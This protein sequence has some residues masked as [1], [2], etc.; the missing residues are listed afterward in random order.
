M[1]ASERR[2]RLLAASALVVCPLVF[3][4][5]VFE[6]AFRI[7]GALG[8]VPLSAELERDGERGWR[9][10]PNFHF[11]GMK[12]DAAD[13]EHPVEIVTDANGF[14]AFGDPG[15]AKCR[16]FFIG[17][18]F[19]FAKDVS[20]SEPFHAVA[21]RRLDLEV[22]AYGADGYG[23]L[24]ELL[25]LDAWMDRIRPDAVVWQFCRNDFIGNQPEFTRGSA[26]N[27]CHVAQ[28]FLF[29]DGSIR[30]I[31]PG[32]GRWSQGVRP[33]PSA[34]LRSLAYRLDNRN[35]FPTLENTVENIIEREGP[36]FPPFQRAAE[37]TERLFGKIQAR[38]G[39]TPL[40]VFDVEAREP[41][42]GAF[43]DICVRRGLARVE[44][45]AEAIQ[46]AAAGGTVVF[47]E[48]GGH[49]NAEGHRICG[50]LLAEALRPL[51]QARRS[52]PVPEDRR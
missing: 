41:Y 12:R 18:S 43:R 15:S 34:L 47:A 8:P 21:G 9:T 32:E 46:Q 40:L 5:L 20:Q 29:P 49:W 26:K 10:R 11:S 25:V 44:G 14:R 38:C 35:G 24:Q 6:A 36:Q 27:Q 4:F 39:E 1:P 45:V 31:N 17:D 30:R 42:S 52:A 33:L 28:P 16:V 7:K 37:T 23:T 13:A 2:K 19:T 48:D 3:V 22:F 51:C 50:E